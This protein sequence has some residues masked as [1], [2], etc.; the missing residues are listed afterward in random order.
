MSTLKIAIAL[1]V[2][3]LAAL[4]YT[5]WR[6]RLFSKKWHTAIEHAESTL[7]YAAYEVRVS[8][9]TPVGPVMRIDY[10]GDDLQE[11][12]RVFKTTAAPKSSL[13]ELYTRGHHTASRRIG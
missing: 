8:L 10:T 11:A 1:V 4:A 9:Q 3:N 5:F 6:F 13:V 12:K 7:P 2:V